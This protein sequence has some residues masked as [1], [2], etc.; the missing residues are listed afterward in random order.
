M[1]A[2]YTPATP[3]RIGTRG[4]PLALVQANEVARRL[5]TAHGLEDAAVEIVP[6]TT[7]GDKEQSRPLA[8]IGGKGLFAVELETALHE[9]DI[10]LAVHSMKDVETVLH[11]AFEIAAMLPREDTRDAWLSPVANHPRDL[12]Q[13][14]VVGTASLRRGAQVR[15]MR[16]DVKIVNFRG[17]VQSRIDKLTRGDVQGTLL[18]LAGRK[19]LGLEDTATCLLDAPEMIAAVG[20]GAIGIEI[21]KDADEVREV[22]AALDDA[23]TSVCVGC[24]RAM[25]AE[26]DGTCRTPIGGHAVLVEGGRIRL[27]AVL[28]AEDGSQAYRFEDEAP[29]AGALELG[30]RAGRTLKQDAGADFVANMG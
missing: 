28:L 16:P 22:V 1:P 23:E 21:R 30:T 20:Q 29:V 4:S 9:G 25:L 6:I 13:G 5:R 15:A 19:R 10:H 24:E 8:E 26:L 11:E 18:A 14:A 17:N 7:S 12:P 2:S 27:T 3:L